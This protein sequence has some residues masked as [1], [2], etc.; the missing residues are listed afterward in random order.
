M[1]KE[2]IELIGILVVVLPISI[3]AVR[4]FFKGS[5]LFVMSSL[6]VTMVLLTD[7]LVNLKYIYPKIFSTYVTTP[8]LVILG[9]WILWYIAQRIRKPLDQTIDDLRKIS[10]GELT[11][12]VNQEFERRNDELGQLTK[13]VGNLSRK[14]REVMEGISEAARELESSASQF[15]QSAATLSSVASEQSSSLEEISSTL[16]E[17][18]AN[19]QQNAENAMQTEKIASTASKNLEEGVVSTNVALDSMNEIAQ[20]IGI[21]SDIAVQTNLLAINATVEAAR[22]GEQGKGFAVVAAEVRRLAERTREAASAIIEVSQKG[23]EISGKAK[24]IINRNLEEILRTSILIREISAAT[25]E[26][27]SGAEQI[28]T[29]VL[30]LNNATQQNASLSE[31]VAASAE[32]LNTRAK[33]LNDLIAYFKIR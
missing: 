10:E 31:E 19:I 15:T 1:K 23:A 2:L 7:V 3:L 25:N 29:S 5:I 30:V 8:F 24:D 28:N 26:Q 27:R 22:A 6:F 13:A 20:R 12:K 4:F 16:E 21:I 9:I 32:E 11:V 18:L 17:I 33:S 14:L